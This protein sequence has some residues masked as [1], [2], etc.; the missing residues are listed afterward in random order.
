MV[1]DILRAKHLTTY[2]FIENATIFICC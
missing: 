1:A 2:I